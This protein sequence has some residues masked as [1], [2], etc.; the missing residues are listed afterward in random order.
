MALQRIAPGLSQKTLLTGKRKF[1]RDIDLSF[2]PKPGGFT[3]ID[4]DGSGNLLRGDDGNYVFIERKG[5]IYKKTDVAAILQ[6]VENIL[7]TNTREKPF[8]PSFGGNLRRMLFDNGSN[9]SANYVSDL[10]KQEL[11]RWE[12]RV[13]VLSVKYKRGKEIVSQ[14]AANLNRPNDHDISIILDLL[15]EDKG[16]STTINLSRLR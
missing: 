4:S 15:I 5:D 3:K 12:P 8:E 13:S 2:T 14:S 11:G 7:L 1:S 10:I 9:V 16:F 6:S